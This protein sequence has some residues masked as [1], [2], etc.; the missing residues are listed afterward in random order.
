MLRPKP[1]I[2]RLA[3]AIHGGINY[4]EIEKAGIS[5]GKLLDFSVN[6]NPFGPPPG[7]TEAICQASIDRYPDSESAE[8]RQSIAKKSH[9]NGNNV[10]VGSGSTELIRM[11]ATAYFG[12]GDLVIVPPP[13]YSEYEIACRLVDADVK[14]PML[15]TEPDLRL[16]VA[17][18]VEIVRTRKPKGIFLCNPN[19][20]TGQYLSRK[21]VEAILAVA[22]DTLVILDEAYIAFTK[23]SWSAVDLIKKGNVIILRSMTKDYALAGLRLGYAIADESI[24]SVLE[25]VKPPWNVSSAAQAAGIT[26]LKAEGYIES[27]AVKINQARDFL[28]QELLRLGCAP[29]PSQTN[30]FLVKV[31]DAAGLRQIL[32]RQGILVRDCASFG[33]HNYIRL[34]PRPMPECEM[35]IAK[36]MLPEV[37][38]HVS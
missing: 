20:P 33:L 15:L 31:K 26:A 34:S 1:N 6:T 25:R 11:V 24:I 30:F 2:E 13:T 19:N 23:N 18:L 14:L 22:Q 5:A 12:A 7:V 38:L 9:I 32:F 3:E 27:C 8:L 36:L 10:I 21:D 29:L 37:R 4:A 16:N 35:L 17:E 28:V